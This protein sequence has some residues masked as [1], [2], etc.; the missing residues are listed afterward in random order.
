[1]AAKL[2]V[3]GPPSRSPSGDGL[4]RGR[5]RRRDRRSMPRRSRPSRAGSRSR[6]SGERASARSSIQGRPKTKPEPGRDPSRVWQSRSA[7]HSGSLPETAISGDCR[8]SRPGA[9]SELPALEPQHP[10]A[11]PAAGQGPI[12]AADWS[13]RPEPNVEPKLSLPSPELIR[14][15]RRNPPNVSRTASGTMPW[16]SPMHPKS[17]G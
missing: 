3:S 17:R 16:R 9:A 13:L 8:R 14:S 2:E 7:G 4:N 11:T 15:Q 1:M 5:R 12:A 10:S 6:G